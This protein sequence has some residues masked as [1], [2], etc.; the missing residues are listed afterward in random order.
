MDFDSDHVSDE[1]TEHTTTLLTHLEGVLDQA[2]LEAMQGAWGTLEEAA[3][4][5]YSHARAVRSRMLWQSMSPAD[6]SD[7]A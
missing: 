4:D 5:S 6:L 1:L 3:T 7:A 2:M